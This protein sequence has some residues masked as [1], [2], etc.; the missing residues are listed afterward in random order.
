MTVT[1]Y[2]SVDGDWVDLVIDGTKYFGGH[3]LPAERAIRY[4]ARHMKNLPT[5]INTIKVET[6][7]VE[8]DPYESNY[9]LY[10]TE[11]VYLGTSEEKDF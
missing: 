4:L 3:S 8:L 7:D 1:F 10:G 5:G 6:I 9:V 11:K 2:K